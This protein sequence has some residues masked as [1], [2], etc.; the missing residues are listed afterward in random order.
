M[1]KTLIFSLSILMFGCAGKPSNINTAVAVKPTITPTSVSTLT[2]SPSVTPTTQVKTGKIQPMPSFTFTPTPTPTAT[3]E[4]SGSSSVYKPISQ[5]SSDEEQLIFLD[6]DKAPQEGNIEV[7]RVRYLLD[8]MAENT[9]TSRHEVANY[10]SKTVT[11]LEN[12]FGK[13]VK[14]LEFLER[15]K[16]FMDALPTK[17]AKK[18]DYNMI[19]YVIYLDL[20]K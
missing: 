8:F 13:R 20:S 3:P 12:K 1:K 16:K 6:S 11:M 7:K 17:K 5:N 2:P 14:H 15:A 4:T 9:S 19:A 10:T 18:E